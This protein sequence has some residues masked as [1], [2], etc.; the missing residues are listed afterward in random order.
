MEKNLR[1]DSVIS[2]TKKNYL[3]IDGA[4]KCLSFAYI[5]HMHVEL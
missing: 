1:H 5:C 4:E 3:T 2:Y